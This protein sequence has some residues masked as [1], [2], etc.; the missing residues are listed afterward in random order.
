M[1]KIL[2]AEADARLDTIVPGKVT[3]KIKAYGQ[4]TMMV[5]VYFETD[6]VGSEHSHPHEQ[7]SYCL[8]G[9]FEFRIS[10]KAMK[11]GVGDTILV[12]GGAAHGVTCLKK[13]R[14]LDVFSPP[15]ED[16]LA[17]S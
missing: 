11:V 7:L 10:G 15:R 12:P 14:L 8:E 13:G 5:E 17:R 4:K 6:A 9:E 1:D 2:F 16:F 3:R